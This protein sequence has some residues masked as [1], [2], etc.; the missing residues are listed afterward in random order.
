MLSSACWL[1]RLRATLTLQDGGAPPT[2][3]SELL[4]RTVALE[5][6]L[7]RGGL[8]VSEE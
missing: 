3:A 4:L 7:C 8:G 1:R 6:H 2:W 5:S